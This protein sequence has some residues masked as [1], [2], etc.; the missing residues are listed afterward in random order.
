MPDFNAD[1]LAVTDDDHDRSHASGNHSRYGAH[2]AQHLHLLNDDGEPPRPVDFAAIA[3]L[4][5]TGPIMAPGYVRIRPD[6][7]ALTTFVADDHR[8][9][10][11]IAVPLRHHTLTRR[12]T[13]TLD[14]ERQHNPWHDQRWACFDGPELADRPAL[15]VT[16]DLL[17]PVPDRLLITPTTTRPGTT[18][19]RD[20][21]AAVRALAGYANAH[22]HLVADLTGGAR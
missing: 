21:K 4:V 16:A 3:W 7:H 13:R 20:A 15:L 17:I 5:A 19:T 11:R 6:L 2:L 12:P 14:W 22:A 10:L 8:L 1:T 9:A 18:L